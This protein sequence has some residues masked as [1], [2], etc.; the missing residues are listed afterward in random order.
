M[1]IVD[2]LNE[3][4]LMP[5]SRSIVIKGAHQTVHRSHRQQLEGRRQWDWLP[6][7]MVDELY[8]NM[9]FS[10]SNA[11]EDA[12]QTVHRSRRRQWEGRQQLDWLPMVTVDENRSLWRFSG[13]F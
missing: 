5:F 7:V 1:V 4:R 8:E 6:M 10:R 2:E 12:H 3:D 11:I 9:A 13:R